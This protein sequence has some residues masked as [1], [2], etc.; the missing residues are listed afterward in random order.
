MIDPAIAED[1][2][3]L[4][5]LRQEVAPL[6]SQVH[7]I[8]P[9]SVT[10]IAFVGADEGNNQLRFDPFLVQVIRVVDSSN[11]SYA[12]DVITPESDIHELSRR[13]WNDSHSEL[14]KLMRFLNVD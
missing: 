8:Q 4:D 12:V 3:L 11:N 6:R 2:R 14:G 9:R 5:D 7:R 10:S 13:H 1:R